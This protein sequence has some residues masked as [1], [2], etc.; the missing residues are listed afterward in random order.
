M[1]KSRINFHNTI[2]LFHNYS[3]Y[4]DHVSFCVAG[5]NI[6]FKA[7]LFTIEYIFTNTGL[8]WHSITNFKTIYIHSFPISKFDNSQ[9]KGCAF[10][11]I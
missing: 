5:S 2:Q 7:Q 11:R 8:L 10:H 9:I 4:L 3:L 1:N 6:L